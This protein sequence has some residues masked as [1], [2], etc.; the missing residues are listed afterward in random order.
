MG[1][2]SFRSYEI[3]G[4]GGQYILVVPELEMSVVIYGGN[5]FMGYI[6]GRWRDEY[7]GGYLIPALLKGSAEET[8]RGS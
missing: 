5:Y 8:A 3:T 2:R 7:V 1:D 6:W 4:N